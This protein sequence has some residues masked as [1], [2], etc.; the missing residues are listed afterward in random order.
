MQIKSFC[1][2]NNLKQHTIFLRFIYL[3]V[4]AQPLEFAEL[5]DYEQSIFL[6]IFLPSSN[7]LFKRYLHIF[8]SIKFHYNICL[9]RLMM[10]KLQF[11]IRLMSSVLATCLWH[12]EIRWR[13]FIFALQSQ[14]IVAVLKEANMKLFLHR[15]ITTFGMIVLTIKSNDYRLYFMIVTESK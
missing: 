13:S 9:I 1:F 7:I 8:G 5:F 6:V 15:L 12:L 3:I 10:K 14:R 11:F 4:D 2:I